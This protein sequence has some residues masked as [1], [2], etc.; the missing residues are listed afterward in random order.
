MKT[1][2]EIH[3]YWRNPNDNKNN[4]NDYLNGKERT[5]YLLSKIN[6]LNIDKNISILELGCNVGR[7]LNGL[8]NAGYKSLHG[9]EIN[10]NAVKILKKEFPHLKNIKNGTI[11]FYINAFDSA[12]IVYTMA[13]LEHIHDDNAEKIFRE[14]KRISNKYII[15]IEDERK[16]SER[17]FTRNYK[18]V[19]E[20]L[21]LKEVEFE[22]CKKIKGLGRNYFYRLFIKE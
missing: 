1:I 21:G 22:N 20:G 6:A 2:S 4:P 11:E 8:Y 5:D 9:I 17:H 12:D 14:M 15:T 19:F 3:N 16:E 13:V 7:N 10:E 18:T